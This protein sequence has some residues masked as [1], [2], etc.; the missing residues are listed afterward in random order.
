M[1]SPCI[2]VCVIDPGSNL[3]TGCLRTL[4]EIAQWSVMPT[5]QRNKI[6]ADIGRR[7]TLAPQHPVAAR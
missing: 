2:K 1:E 3:C 7:R 5:E 6:M 4:S